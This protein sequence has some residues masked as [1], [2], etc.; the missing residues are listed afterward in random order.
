MR[1]RRPKLEPGTIVPNITVQEA[2]SIALYGVAGS[3][4]T[5]FR[6]ACSGATGSELHAAA[7]V[8]IVLPPSLAQAHPEDQ[9]ELARLLDIVTERSTGSSGGTGSGLPD[10]PSSFA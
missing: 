5:A 10:L 7:L 1:T 3:T 2:Q 9:A 6:A 8:P 4:A